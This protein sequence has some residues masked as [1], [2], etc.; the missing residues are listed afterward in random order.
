MKSATVGTIL[1][2]R[3]KKIGF[4]LI[5]IA[6]FGLLLVVLILPFAAEVEFAKAEVLEGQYLWTRAGEKYQAVTRLNPF[7]AKYFAAAGDFF[8]RQS[9][10][11]KGAERLSIQKTAEKFYE[12]AVKLNSSNGEYWYL[13]GKARME[14]GDSGSA[15]KDFREAI[16]ADLYNVRNNYYVGLEMLSV[17]DS[18][19]AGE[20]EFALRRLKYAVRAKRSYGREK[21]FSEILFYT[22]DFGVV[23][24]VVPASLAGQRAL[25]SFVV[26]NNLWQYRRE[27]AELVAGYRQEEEPEVL[28][29]ERG[30]RERSF[31][32]LRSLRM[33]GGGMTRG[34]MTEGLKEWV[35]K[36]KNGKNV[37]KKGNMY[38]TGMVSM[39]VDVPA[40]E[41]KIK[42]KAKGSEAFGIWPYMVVELDGV[43]IGETF[44]DG[45]EWK[46]YAFSVDTD[47]GT[48]VLSVSFMNDGG[49]KK[50]GTDRNLYVGK[51]RIEK[52]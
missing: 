46:E 17:W 40:G 44:V 16:E 21:I 49:D 50:K 43:E 13:L 6:G 28:A 19:D 9:G 29:A 18:L 34:A 35:G 48:K 22:K 3:V 10:Y 7:D 38:W 45:G 20:R 27:A 4:N 5:L 41:A 47:G 32:S 37:Y 11:Q 51:V 26:K 14:M 30:E 23:K 8:M 31:D 1:G 15:I 33:T 52:K 12:R 24:E 39:A 42:I 2:E 36:S 25:Y